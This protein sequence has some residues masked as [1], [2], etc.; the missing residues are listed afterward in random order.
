DGNLA[1]IHA[2][3]TLVWST[4][5]FNKG[6]VGIELRTNR[7]LVLYDKNNRS[8]WH[9]FDHP[10][11]TL[12]VG[13]SLKIDTV[14]KLVSRASEK[15]G[16]EGPYSLVMEAGGFVMYASFLTPLPYNTL[17]YYDNKIKGMLEAIPSYRVCKR[18]LKLTYK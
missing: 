9:S 10:I 14:K 15:D 13:Q 7:N 16:S 11:D 6:V 12:L 8:V 1:L 18:P 17:S 5:T 3:G 4:N 2:D